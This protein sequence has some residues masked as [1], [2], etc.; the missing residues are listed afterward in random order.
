VSIRFMSVR[1][2]PRRFGDLPDLPGRPAA[3]IRAVSPESFESAC[4]S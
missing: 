2:L 4:R 3:L 1:L